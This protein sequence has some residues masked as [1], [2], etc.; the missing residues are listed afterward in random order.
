MHLNVYLYS[1][2]QLHLDSQSQ[3]G[4]TPFHIPAV[5][6]LSPSTQ[7]LVGSPVRPN[8]KSVLQE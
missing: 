8:P 3:V 6:S 1:N 5:V 2:N 4:A 7:V